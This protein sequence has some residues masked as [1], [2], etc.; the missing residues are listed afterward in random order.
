MI[1]TKAADNTEN[2][3]REATDNTDNAENTDREATDNTENAENTDRARNARTSVTAAER[4]ESGDRGLGNAG[5]GRAGG[6]I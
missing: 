2:T 3:D 1:R 5:A 4:V 6:E